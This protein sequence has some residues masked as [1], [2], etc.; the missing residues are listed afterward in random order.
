MTK[1]LNENEFLSSHTEFI[2]NYGIPVTPKEFAVVFD[3]IP[4]G[5]LNL[6]QGY[7]MFDVNPQFKYHLMLDCTRT[8]IDNALIIIL[9]NSALPVKLF[10]N[11]T[12]SEMF[13]LKSYI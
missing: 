10:Y 9:G 6:M 12:R 11:A 5:L 4:S 2:C 3:G 8:Q 13:H 7:S 1:L